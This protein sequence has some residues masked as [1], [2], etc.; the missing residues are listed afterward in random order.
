MPAGSPSQISGMATAIETASGIGETTKESVRFAIVEQ[1]V[2]VFVILV[3]VT[4]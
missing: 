4:L 2:A 1:F 3:M